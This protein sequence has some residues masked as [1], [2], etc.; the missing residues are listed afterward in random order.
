MAGPGRAGPCAARTVS[1]GAHPDLSFFL[2]PAQLTPF[3]WN[4]EYFAKKF[5]VLNAVGALVWAVAFAASA[6][7]RGFVENVLEKVLNDVHHIELL[8]SGSSPDLLLLWLR[9]I[10]RKK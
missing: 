1:G 10:S 7:V 9:K 4:H 5:F 6:T 3:T 8:A 2:R